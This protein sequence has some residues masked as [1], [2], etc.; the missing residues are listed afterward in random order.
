MERS[1]EMKK[2]LLAIVALAAAAAP[3]AEVRLAHTVTLKPGWNAV[4]LP[5][6]PDA[7]ADAL[8]NE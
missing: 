1:S 2:I 4:F 6:A 5:V 7:P 8:A 3:A